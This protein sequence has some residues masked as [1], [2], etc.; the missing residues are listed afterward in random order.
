MT[1]ALVI[2]LARFG[3]LVQTKRLVLTLAAEYSA[4]LCVDRSLAPLAR[5]LYPQ[6]RVHPVAAHGGSP[7]EVA[8]FNRAAFA[9]L[10]AEG[11]HCVYN[12]NHSPLNRALARLFSAETV[13]GHYVDKGQDMRSPWVDLAFR[14]TTQRRLAPLNLADF[15]AFLHPSPLPPHAVNPVARPGGKGLGVVLSGREARRSLPAHVLAPCV[16]AAFACLDG[17]DV[18]LLGAQSEQA[19][20]RGLARRLPSAMLDK[21]RNLCGKTDWAG[22]M[23][24]LAGLDCLLSPDT[25]AMHLAAHLGVPV[26]AFFLSSAWCHETGPYGSGHQVWQA[27]ADCLPCLESAPCTLDVRCLAP[28]ARHD[29]LAAFAKVL[30]KGD[31]SGAQGLPPHILHLESTLDALGS[32]WTLR[33]GDDPHSARRNALRALLGEYLGLAPCRGQAEAAAQLY[34]EEDWMLTRL[35]PAS[36][37]REYEKPL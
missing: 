32:A 7:A 12:L 13:Y 20:A 34:Q 24:A 11:F 2:Q 29:F 23:D 19:L 10:A 25:G 14:W 26:Q 1:P 36:G 30:G 6:A 15:W 22:L 33:Q 16:H 18:Y 37:V 28:F 4:H 21:V 31:L 9:A 17:P 3:D 5:L 8:D 35:A 27:D